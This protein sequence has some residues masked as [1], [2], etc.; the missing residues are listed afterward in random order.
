MI[1]IKAGQRKALKFGRVWLLVKYLTMSTI[2]LTAPIE[3]LAQKSDITP[4][5][6]ILYQYTTRI[7]FSVALRVTGGSGQE[8]LRGTFYLGTGDRFRLSTPDQEII[9][10]G[11]WLWT[12]DKAQRQVVVE[13]FDPRSS[14]SGVRNLL[15]GRL[16][17][18]KLTPV[19]LRSA[20]PHG[21]TFN[22]QA[23][24]RQAFL[25]NIRVEL[26]TLRKI[27]LKAE[28]RDIQQHTW[29]VYFEAP[30]GLDSTREDFFKYRT[31][32]GEELLDL[33]P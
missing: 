13:P 27:L 17:D 10:D 28:Y 30:V 3:L 16:Q 8:D 14:L 9:Y 19:H 32:A 23:R 7:P 4:F 33:R 15:Q 20:Q 24:D 12:Q 11:K 29:A 26:D 22:L 2:L 18:Y 5:N 25:Q 6:T 21:L 1:I 31:V